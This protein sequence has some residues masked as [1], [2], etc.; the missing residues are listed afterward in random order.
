MFYAGG[1]VLLYT[2]LAGIGLLRQIRGFQA[3]A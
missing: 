2:L 1:V 3:A